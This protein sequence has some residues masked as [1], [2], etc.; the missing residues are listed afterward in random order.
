MPLHRATMSAPPWSHYRNFRSGYMKSAS[1]S[2]RAPRFCLPRCVA[3]FL[4]SCFSYTLRWWDAVMTGQCVKGPKY[5]IRIFGITV[6]I[7]VATGCLVLMNL[8]CFYT[9]ASDAT[10]WTTDLYGS[11]STSHRIGQYFA[12][13]TFH[14]L[15]WKQSFRLPAQ[16]DRALES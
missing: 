8:G 11:A 1:R 9:H 10:E 16:W 6:H 4:Y 7:L 5:S 12:K 14:N 3:G 13:S 15:P 2:Q